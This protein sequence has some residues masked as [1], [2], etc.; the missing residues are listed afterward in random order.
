MIVSKNQIYSIIRRMKR[1][2]M[3]V[4]ERSELRN[5]L[6]QELFATGYGSADAECRN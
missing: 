2:T 4:I 5:E 3:I 1:N 6:W